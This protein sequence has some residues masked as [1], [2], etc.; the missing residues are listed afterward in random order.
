MILRRL[1]IPTV[2]S[3][4]YKNNTTLSVL[5]YCVFLISI[6]FFSFFPCFKGQWLVLWPHCP[7]YNCLL[8]TVA[9]YL[10]IAAN[11]D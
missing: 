9:L 5:C 3:T 10:L 1:H 8:T 2:H 11:E 4:A 6:L 7:V